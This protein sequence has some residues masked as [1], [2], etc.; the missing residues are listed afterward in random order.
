MQAPDAGHNT[1]SPSTVLKII[2]AVLLVLAL[3]AGLFAIHLQRQT[4]RAEDL[5]SEL[6]QYP[7]EKGIDHA[8][9]M[10]ML[11][12]EI[13]HH[14][15]LNGGQFVSLESSIDF[16]DFYLLT[17]DSVGVKTATDNFSQS[18]LPALHHVHIWPGHSCLDER[19]TIGNNLSYQDILKKAE[20]SSR[21]AHAIVTRSLD[22]GF[23]PI[24]VC[25]DP[26]YE[27]PDR[28]F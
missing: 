15:I 11:S 27:Q 18:A 25:S 9:D 28:R 13:K 6:K 17:K 10:S 26:Y 16:G 8:I 4:N 14:L 5:L 23:Q 24:I 3:L 7:P 20:V 19:L 12:S 2:P 1:Q 21:G 22:I